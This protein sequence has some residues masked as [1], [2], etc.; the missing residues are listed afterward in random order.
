MFLKSHRSF[1]ADKII[2][3]YVF[4]VSE[5][6]IE[7]NSICFSILCELFVHVSA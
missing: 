3:F 6:I 7:V 2:L 1:C 4:C 5:W